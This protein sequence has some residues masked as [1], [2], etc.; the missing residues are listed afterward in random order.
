VSTTCRRNFDGKFLVDR[1]GNVYSTTTEELDDK[2]AE[3]L[4]IAEEF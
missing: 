1:N 3:L 2:L 4:D